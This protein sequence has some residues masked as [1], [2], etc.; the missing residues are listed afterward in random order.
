MLH[1]RKVTDYQINSLSPKP[2]DYRILF[3]EAKS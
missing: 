3:R 1:R 2:V